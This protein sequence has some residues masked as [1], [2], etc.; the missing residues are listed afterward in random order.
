MSKVA[1]PELK[2]GYKQLEVFSSFPV[3]SNCT[4]TAATY[5]S[6]E[7]DTCCHA[8]PQPGGS[9][10]GLTPTCG[11]WKIHKITP[12]LSIACVKG[13]DGKHQPRTKVGFS[14][15][16]TEH[17]F[18]LYQNSCEAISVLRFLSY[19]LCTAPILQREQSTGI[20]IRPYPWR[21]V[22]FHR[23]KQP[24]FPGSNCPRQKNQE[25]A[26]RFGTSKSFH[27]SPVDDQRL[28]K[29][30]DFSATSS[31]SLLARSVSVPSRS[32]IVSGFVQAT[33]R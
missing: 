15:G 18:E 20:I 1:P 28:P 32:G 10:K 11:A 14:L 2:Q 5:C 21:S 22:I 17:F 16:Y 33:K 19:H 3:Y 7:E 8:A 23:N 26:V 29:A 24:L 12:F 25:H 6:A 31:D 27:L 9:S 4:A 13:I 30:Y